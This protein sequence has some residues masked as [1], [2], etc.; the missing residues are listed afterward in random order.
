MG[1]EWK[2]FVDQATPMSAVMIDSDDH[3]RKPLFHEYTV[4]VSYYQWVA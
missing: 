2:L 3:A 1:A 4:G